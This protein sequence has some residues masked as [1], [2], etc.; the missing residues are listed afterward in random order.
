[1]RG[2]PAEPSAQA[3]DTHDSEAGGRHLPRWWHPVNP[4]QPRTDATC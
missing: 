3:D 2:R 1:M 4:L